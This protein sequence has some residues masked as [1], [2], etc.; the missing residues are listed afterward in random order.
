MSMSPSIVGNNPPDVQHYLDLKYAIE[1]QRANAA[2]LQAQG[3]SA[4]DFANAGQIPANAASSRGLNAANAA[5][6]LAAAKTRTALDA[7]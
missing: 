4:V 2:T 3:G 7:R 5:D 1:Q 6:A